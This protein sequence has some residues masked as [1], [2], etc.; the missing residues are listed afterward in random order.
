M[1]LYVAGTHYK[2]DVLNKAKIV[3][4]FSP[5]DGKHEDRVSVWR[6]LRATIKFQLKSGRDPNLDGHLVGR[7]LLD[8]GLSPR[9]DNIDS[10]LLLLAGL[11]V[12]IFARQR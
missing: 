11:W 12:K 9:A 5:K 10:H 6:Q 2:L 8:S 7:L 4:G 1:T 3:F